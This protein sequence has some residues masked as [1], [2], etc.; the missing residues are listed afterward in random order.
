MFAKA[1]SLGKQL[2]DVFE[3]F[4]LQR[5]ATRIE[6]EHGRL[7]AHLALKAN[8]WLDNERGFPGFESIGQRFPLIPAMFDQNAGTIA[9]WYFSSMNCFSSGLCKA[10]TSFCM[11]I[12]SLFSG[13][14]TRI[15]T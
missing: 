10:T 11:A 8:V 6:Q 13:R 9:P 14:A 5:I 2:P 7:L 15:F 4:E 12:E 1:T 3:G